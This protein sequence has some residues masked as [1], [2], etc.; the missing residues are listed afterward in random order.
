MSDQALFEA[1]KSEFEKF[2]NLYHE[3]IVRMYLRDVG[4]GEKTFDEQIH[5]VWD[6]WDVSKRIEF[7][8][9]AFDQLKGSQQGRE[10]IVLGKTCPE[11]ANPKLIAEDP[12]NITKFLNAVAHNMENDSSYPWSKLVRESVIGILDDLNWDLW[13]TFTNKVSKKQ[14]T[15]L[16]MFAQRSMYIN[17]VAVY[18]IANFCGEFTGEGSLPKKP[19]GGK[20]YHCSKPMLSRK[21]CAKCKSVYYC[22]KECQL[23]HWPSHRGV[24]KAK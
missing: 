3:K 2:T 11:V 9:R 18:L 13:K 22:S 19:Q 16:L 14:Y 23:N 24:C 17:Q 8:Q 6:D 20:C 12:A 4:E 10:I 21:R 7:I 5:E 15:E 1:Q